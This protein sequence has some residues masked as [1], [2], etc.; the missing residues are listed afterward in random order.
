MNRPTLGSSADPG[1][2]PSPVI[3]TPLG[4]RGLAPRAGRNF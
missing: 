2:H 4:K 3:G 1:F